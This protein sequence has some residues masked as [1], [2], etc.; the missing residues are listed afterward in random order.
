MKICEIRQTPL[1]SRE[2]GKYSCSSKDWQRKPN[3]RKVETQI[4]KDIF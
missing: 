3:S 4:I 1:T 2:T